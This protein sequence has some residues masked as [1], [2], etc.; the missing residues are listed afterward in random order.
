MYPDLTEFEVLSNSALFNF[1]QPSTPQISQNV[2]TSQAASRRRFASPLAT[3]K[4]VKANLGITG[5]PSN[6]HKYNKYNMSMH[7]NIYNK[8]EA[9]VNHKQERVREEMGDQSLLLVGSNELRFFGQE[10][11]R[12]KLNKV[13]YSTEFQHLYKS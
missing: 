8:N 4:V 3:V 2:T 7:I 13:L 12:G 6:V 5:R 10:A 9:C 11:T 1:R